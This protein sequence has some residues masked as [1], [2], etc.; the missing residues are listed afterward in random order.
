[1]GEGKKKFLEGGRYGCQ[2]DGLGEADTMG[3]EGRRKGG[4]EGGR[5]V[6]ELHGAELVE[7]VG[8]LAEVERVEDAAGLHIR[9]CVREGGR[10]RQKERKKV[11]FA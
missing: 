6:L 3:K 5:T 10:E 8:V 7:L 4:R 11:G 1:V 9:A 2:N